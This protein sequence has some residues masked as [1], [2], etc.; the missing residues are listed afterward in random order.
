MKRKVRLGIVGYGNLGK[1]V[2]LG[3]AGQEDMELVAIFTRR[4]PKSISSRIKGSQVLSLGEVR[5][6]SKKIDVMILCG[7]SDQD[8]PSQ[9]VKF[10][11]QFNTVDS[12]DI[13][14]EI[15]GHYKRVGKAA[16]AGGQVSVISSGWDPGLFSLQRLL[17]EVFFPRG[18]INTLWGRGVSQGH[19]SALRKV[20]GVKYGIQY[21]LPSE[22]VLNELRNGQTVKLPKNEWHLRLCYVVLEKGAKEKE[23]ERNIKEM[24]HYFAPYPTKVHF[25]SEQE[26]LKNH[27]SLEHGGYVFAKGEEGDLLEY[28]LKLK[29]NPDF[30]ARVL[31]ACARAAFRLYQTGAKG[32]YTIF[33]IPP[34]YF[35]QAGGD[36]LRS[37]IL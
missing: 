4:D 25:L 6:Y 10:A 35:H 28:S 30:T 34:K 31:I 7:S 22:Q 19:S 27:S 23:V 15:P 9:A 21:T 29:N 13:H 17:G 8:L 11:R 1:G 37:K 32:A 18:T 20:T 33:D 12:F 14:E 36:Y 16:R 2:E 24:K 3:I 5:S 26:F